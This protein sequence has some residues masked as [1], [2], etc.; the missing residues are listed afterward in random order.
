MPFC[1]KCGR[2]LPPSS[3]SCTDCGTSTTGAIIKIKKTSAAHVYKAPPEIKV[4]KAFAPKAETVVPV[5]PVIATKPAP[6]PTAPAKKETF[7]EP[8]PKATPSVAAEE[9]KHEIKQSKLS[10]EEDIITNPHDYETQT[11]DFDLRCR[12]D[13]FFPPGST[14]PVSKGKAYCPVCGE[15]LRNNEGGKPRRYHSF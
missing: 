9:P 14:L 11:F 13:H 2:C 1:R 8:I 12:H 6:K 5:K 4:V 3:E 10:I 15:Q 7:P